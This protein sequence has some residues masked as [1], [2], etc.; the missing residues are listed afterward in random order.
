MANKPVDRAKAMEE[1]RH[2]RPGCA[3]WLSRNQKNCSCGR[4][5]VLLE[6]VR[7]TELLKAAKRMLELK[8]ALDEKQ[9]KK[10]VNHGRL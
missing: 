6:L 5:A 8:Q 9:A 7:V 4:N 10:S 3:Y 2:H 1:L